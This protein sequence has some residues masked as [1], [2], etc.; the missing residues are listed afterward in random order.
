MN[1][2]DK[3]AICRVDMSDGSGDVVFDA[4]ISYNQSSVRDRRVAKNHFI[5]FLGAAVVFFLF[6]F[7]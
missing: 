5:K 6:L 7:Y 2:L 4:R 3:R 1:G